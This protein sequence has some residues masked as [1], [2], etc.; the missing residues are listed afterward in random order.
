VQAY[1]D[2]LFTNDKFVGVRHRLQSDGCLFTGYDDVAPDDRTY[3]VCVLCGSWTVTELGDRQKDE[4]EHRA[5]P[6]DSI[7]R[8]AVSGLYGRLI[9]V[10]QY[11][12]I[13]RGQGRNRYNGQQSFANIEVDQIGH[14]KTCTYYC[15]AGA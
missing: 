1:R 3:F 14:S 11:E 8:L 4:E 9:H 15:K 2:R 5:Q 12:V 10:P 7:N 13:S 6:L